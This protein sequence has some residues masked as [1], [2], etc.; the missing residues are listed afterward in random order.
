MPTGSA[1][2]NHLI[3]DSD[4]AASWHLQISQIYSL[5]TWAYFSFPLLFPDLCLQQFNAVRTR[6]RIVLACHILIILPEPISLQAE[7]PSLRPLA[8]PYLSSSLESL[9]TNIAHFWIISIA[10]TLC[11]RLVFNLYEVAT[12][13]STS[14]DS[15][16][17]TEPMTIGVLTTRVELDIPIDDDYDNRSAVE[18]GGR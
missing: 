4:M 10:S 1:S 7:A 17:S 6:R 16:S 8:G 11:S 5:S 13:D 2:S 3:S 18:S 14:T 9:K 12:P 15:E